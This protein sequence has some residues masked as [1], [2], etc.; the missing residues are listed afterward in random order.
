MK[1]IDELPKDTAFTVEMQRVMD[2][3]M[4]QTGA[5][6]QRPASFVIEGTPACA[7]CAWKAFVD[8]MIEMHYADSES[9]AYEWCEVIHEH[10]LGT[11]WS[12]EHFHDEDEKETHLISL[13]KL[14]KPE[15]PHLFIGTSTSKRYMMEETADVS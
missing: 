14:I 2:G 12:F 1:R 9:V 6:H 3:I 7:L 13:F 4:C 10:S 11:L 8:N 5:G 15:F